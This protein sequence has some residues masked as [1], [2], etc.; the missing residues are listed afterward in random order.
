MYVFKNKNDE[1]FEHEDFYHFRT[2]PKVGNT[3]APVTM[4]I[5]GD[6]GLYEHSKETLK[7][8]ANREREFDSILLVGDISYANGHHK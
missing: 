6:V 4:A 1:K 8:M 5:I 7:V 3:H 2:A